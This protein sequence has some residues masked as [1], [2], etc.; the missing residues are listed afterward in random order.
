MICIQGGLIYH[1]E[2]IVF[3]INKV[4]SDI[5]A[6]TEIWLN[7]NTPNEAVNIDGYTFCR[8]SK[9]AE[10]KGAQGTYAVVFPLMKCVF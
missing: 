8:K 1:I 6:I 4:K 10:L 3:T 9:P 7:I 5:L 2:E